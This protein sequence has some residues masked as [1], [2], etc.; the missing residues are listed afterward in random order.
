MR[1][2]WVCNAMPSYIAKRIGSEQNAGGGWIDGLGEAMD[3][4][5]DIEFAI[6]ANYQQSSTSIFKTMWGNGS[7][8]YGFRKAEI[9]SHKYDD[10]L[11]E[12]FK[13]IIWEFSP[14]ILH[15]FGTEYAHALAAVKAFAAPQQTVVHIQGMISFIARHYTGMLPPG[16]VNSWTFRD[17]IRHDNIR[18]QQKKFY[19]RGEFEKETFKRAGFITGRNMQ[20]H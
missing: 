5:R 18:N 13:Q 8:F 20:Q 7:V 15:V 10:T 11:D 16:V 1:V 17:L 6:C 12:L 3:C 14:D 19:A 9:Q 2:L 4:S